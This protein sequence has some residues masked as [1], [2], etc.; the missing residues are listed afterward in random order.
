MQCASEY[1]T[2]F[3]EFEADLQ[4]AWSVRKN[5]HHQGGTPAAQTSPSS[6]APN[7]HGQ[8]KPG[9]YSRHG[10]IPAQQT[11]GP[12]SV[13]GGKEK[14]TSLY[15]YTLSLHYLNFVN[16]CILSVNMSIMDPPIESFV[17]MMHT[18]ALELSVC[19]QH[20]NIHVLRIGNSLTVIYQCSCL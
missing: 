1:T 5:I 10:A 8:A 9:Q 17:F 3:A 14:G 12:K 19:S 11:S 16:P 7:V 20:H 13:F 18:E 15:T 6:S 4:A 2:F